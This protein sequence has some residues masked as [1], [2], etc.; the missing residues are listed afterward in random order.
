MSDINNL[1][2]LLTKKI[3]S[4][5][6]YNF[7][8][9]LNPDGTVGAPR[10]SLNFYQIRDTILEVLKNYMSELYIETKVSPMMLKQMDKKQ[11]ES[12]M[13]SALRIEA[14]KVVSK[15]MEDSD[16]FTSFVY[17]DDYDLYR[18]IKSIIVLK[19]NK[20]LKET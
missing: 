5:M 17:E 19:T 13:N 18:E 12:F 6:Y 9:E 8:A 15:I 16:F 10:K 7:R 4:E 14:S 1:A 20:I 3:E 11:I 2:I